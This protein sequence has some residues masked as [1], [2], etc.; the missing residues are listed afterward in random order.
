[1]PE[2]PHVTSSMWGPDGQWTGR[3]ATVESPADA[4]AQ[5]PDAATHRAWYLAG[6]GCAVVIGLVLLIP[7]FALALFS[8]ASALDE[9]AE[10]AEAVV[11]AVGPGKD[12]E[13]ERRPYCYTVEYVVDVTRTHRTCDTL[14]M[15]KLTSPLGSDDRTWETE[16]EQ[17]RRFAA[18]HPVGSRVKLLYEVN[19]PDEVRGPISEVGFSSSGGTPMTAAVTGVLAALCVAGSFFAFYKAVAWGRRKRSGDSG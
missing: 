19:D 2:D 8:L 9:G 14:L 11:V 12:E 7:A 3:P 4:D 15:P 16:Q 10:S 6:S 1:M 5:A 17:E 18:E 13:G